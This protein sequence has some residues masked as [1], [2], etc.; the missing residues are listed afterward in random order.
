LKK[1]IFTIV[2][3]TLFLGL[4][5]DSWIR[6]H[7]FSLLAS[8]PALALAILVLSQVVLAT[9]VLPCSPLTALAGLLWGVE[10]G[11][12]YSTAATV[13][14]SLWTFY[15]ARRVLHGRFAHRFRSHSLCAR[16]VGLIDTH[17]W[18]ASLVAH[19]NPVFPGASLGYAFG[20]SGLGVRPFLLGAFVGT[21]PLQLMLVAFGHV[22]G[23][24]TL[25]EAT[26]W[27]LLSLLA[28]GAAWGFYRRVVPRLLDGSER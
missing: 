2:W 8:H 28:L 19:A 21:L 9:F 26:V 23:R 15:F 3:I 5:L 1:V 24:A 12:V 14:A 11:I 17:G 20:L 6:G 10:L 16:I 27:V 13:I 25:Q 22:L 4:L 7:L 18:K